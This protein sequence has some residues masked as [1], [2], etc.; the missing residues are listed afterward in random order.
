VKITDPVLEKIVIAVFAFIRSM[1]MKKKYST[2]TSPAA[3]FEFR[4]LS[5][6]RHGSGADEHLS[7]AVNASAFTSGDL[8]SNVISRNFQI[9]W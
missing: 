7:S 4:E 2:P 3:Q 1:L 9:F 6:C 5:R 8:G